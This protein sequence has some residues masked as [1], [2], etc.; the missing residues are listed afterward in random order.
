MVLQAFTWY[1]MV[2]NNIRFPKISP[3]YPQDSPKIS[4]ISQD[5][6]KIFPIFPQDFPVCVWGEMDIPFE[7]AN[8]LMK[9]GLFAKYFLWFLKISPGTYDP[10]EFLV[11][12]LRIVHC[13]TPPRPISC[14]CNSPD[15]TRFNRYR[16]V[17]KIGAIKKLW[18]AKSFLRGGWLSSP[19]LTARHPLW[20]NINWWAER[21]RS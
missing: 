19:W 8:S 11:T 16:Y 15:E 7:G 21:A 13:A 17:I 10:Q 12:N 18:V 1:L 3:W 4:K 5:S 6:S 20:E 9:K 2:F 14:V